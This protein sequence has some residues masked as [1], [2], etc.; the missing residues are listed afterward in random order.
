MRHEIDNLKEEKLALSTKLSKTESE[1]QALIEKIETLKQ[2][3]TTRYNEENE[4]KLRQEIETEYNEKYENLLLYTSLVILFFLFSVAITVWNILGTKKRA[5]SE[6]ESSCEETK[7]RLEEC[8]ESR[9]AAEEKYRQLRNENEKLAMGIDSP[10]LKKIES[11]ERR[12]DQI[13]ALMLRGETK[14]G[15]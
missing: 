15:E 8:K 5:L 2:E 14:H 11:K 10:I 6:L 3:G 12:R 9:D 13:L 1:K 7:K 4:E